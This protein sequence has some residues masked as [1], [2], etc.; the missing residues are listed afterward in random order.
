[1]E[2][3]HVTTTP[4]T[5]ETLA[6]TIGLQTFNRYNHTQTYRHATLTITTTIP[7]TQANTRKNYSKH[8]HTHTHTPLLPIQALDENENYQLYLLSN[9]LLQIGPHVNWMIVDSITHSAIL[10]CALCSTGDSHEHTAK[11]DVPSFF[12]GL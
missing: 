7:Q 12:S 9:M 8:T 2:G 3:F 6:V 1:M 5:L 4:L 10:R 11:T